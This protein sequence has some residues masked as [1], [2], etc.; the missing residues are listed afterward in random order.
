MADRESAPLSEAERKELEALR[1]EKARRESEA[2]EAERRE[3]EALRAEQEQVDAEILRERAQQEAR[4]ES[5]GPHDPMPSPPASPEPARRAAP[6][7]DP[8]VDPD[9][10]TFGQ[11]MVLTPAS[12]DPDEIPGM[13]PAQKIILILALLG[14]ALLVYYL[15][16]R[17]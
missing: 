9:N 14:V 2:A 4:P 15:V 3:L 6:A 10:L 17:P 11:R 1:A 13:P 7:E 5:S 16:T 12:D 8:I